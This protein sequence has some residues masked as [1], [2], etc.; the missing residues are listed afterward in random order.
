VSDLMLF[1]V[2]QM[3]YDMAMAD[4]LSRRQYYDRA[5]QALGMIEAMRS[6]LA[7]ALR[8]SEEWR[9]DAERYRWLRD[10]PLGSPHE[11]IG[12]MPGDMW[13]AAIDAA[14]KE[15]V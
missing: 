15:G 3:P 1:G 2:L 14:R 9:R 12:N 13:D 7:A 4:E 8:E 11:A 5:Q 6:E 10:L